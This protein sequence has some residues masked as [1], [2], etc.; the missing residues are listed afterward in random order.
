MIV[1][2]NSIAR[3]AVATAQSLAVL[4]VAA[5]AIAAC[6]APD[7]SYDMS[8]GMNHI[9]LPANEKALQQPNGLLK[10][11]LMPAQEQ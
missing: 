9:P 7:K 4:A 2:R 1:K 10:N 3:G 11:G 6:S 8:T 5:V